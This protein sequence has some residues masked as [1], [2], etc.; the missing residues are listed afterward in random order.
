MIDYVH[1]GYQ[2]IYETEPHLKIKDG[3]LVGKEMI[4]NRRTRE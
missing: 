4:D 2:S 1:M 3:I